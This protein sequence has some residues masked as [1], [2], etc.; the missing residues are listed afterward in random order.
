MNKKGFTLV[1]LSIVLVIIGLLIGGILVGQS[2]IFSF[3]MNSLNSTLTQ[4]EVLANQFKQKYKALP[5][6]FNRATTVLGPTVNGNGNQSIY[7]AELRYAFQHMALARLMDSKFLTIDASIV[8][9]NYNTPHQIDV[10][11]MKTSFAGVGANYSDLAGLQS[12]D[13]AST[14]ILKSG[15]I[16][17][18]SKVTAGDTD[19]RS[20]YGHYS[21][22]SGANGD[23]MSITESKAFD[24][25][26]DD[27]DARYGKIYWRGQG[28]TTC[29]GT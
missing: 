12:K 8:G 3:K 25:K 17:H 2:L 18:V 5:G 16:V 23:F 6:D 21:G 27:G 24:S 7:S 28:S 13:T 9:N 19:F 4:M 14:G 22:Y 29:S 11:L 20:H 15:T 26:F 1:E 10:N